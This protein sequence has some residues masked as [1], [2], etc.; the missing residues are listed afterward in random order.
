MSLRKKVGEV[1]DYKERKRRQREI[2]NLKERM[3]LDELTE[4]DRRRQAAGGRE[5]RD[6]L[7]LSKD[8]N[9]RQLQIEVSL[10]NYLQR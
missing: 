1:Q 9:V 10:K 8:K 6:R 4:T 3:L 2:H 7:H 5:N